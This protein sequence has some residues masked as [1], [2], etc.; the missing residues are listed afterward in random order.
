MNN[1]IEHLPC[2]GF[3][4]LPLQQAVLQV[5]ASNSVKCADVTN[6]L[7]ATVCTVLVTAILNEPVDKG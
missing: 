3:A 5:L 4:V 7:H 2:G 1:T 6:V